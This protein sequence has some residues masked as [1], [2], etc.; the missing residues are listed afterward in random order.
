[1]K[2]GG[3]NSNIKKEGWTYLLDSADN[4]FVNIIILW[5]SGI[6]VSSTFSWMFPHSLEKYLKAYLL[7]IEQDPSIIPQNNPPTE[8]M[9]KEI[10]KYRHNVKKLWKDFKNKSHTSTNKP[11]L[12]EAFE[13]MIKD[14]STIETKQRYQGNIEF[15]S[16]SFFYY[17]IVLSS[18]IRYLTIGKKKYR[19][20]LY[21]LKELNFIP[22]IYK[23]TG[24]GSG[25]FIVE[26]VL[27]LVLEH[28]VS[29]TNLGDLIQKDI[30]EYSISNTAIFSKY[31][32]CPLCNSNGEKV[33]SMKVI[34]YFNE[35]NIK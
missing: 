34:E 21:G 32:N 14:V 27:H 33:D 31:N 15:T 16:S 8:E 25:K 2:F 22:M 24:Q 11:K 17:Y 7:K 12:N 1:M 28:A 35:I 4:D 30:R 13:Q 3:N 19:E 29:P 20:S 10:F 23:E 18:Y 26:K 6:I 5:Y 9:I